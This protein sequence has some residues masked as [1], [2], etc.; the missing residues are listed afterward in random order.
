MKAV[1]LPGCCSL[2]V[3]SVG[4]PQDRLGVCPQA[5]RLARRPGFHLRRRG[6]SARGVENAFE[7]GRINPRPR[8]ADGD[9]D[10]SASVC[11]VLTC[12]SRRSAS[13]EA[14]ASIAFRTRFRTEEYYSKSA[15]ACTWPCS[16]T[17]MDDAPSSVDPWHIPPISN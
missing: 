4:K 9:K 16:I 10:P 3:Q 6:G 13:T 8:I 17:Q 1:A 2:N 15:H 7:T 11:S 12:N 14:I 5:G